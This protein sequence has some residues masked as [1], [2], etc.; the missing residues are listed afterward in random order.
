MFLL[1]E[2]VAPICTAA[3]EQYLSS[4]DYFGGAICQIALLFGRSNQL[5]I[6]IN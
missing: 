4:R 6:V 3:V 2:P 1:D 5:L